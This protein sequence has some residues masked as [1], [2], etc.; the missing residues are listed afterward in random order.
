MFLF[1]LPL[2]LFFVIFLILAIP[3]VFVLLQLGIIS[4]AFEK[5]GV[6]A[7]LAILF[8]AISLLT[9][10]IN[11][12]VYKRE[13]AV[14][15]NTVESI[16]INFLGGIPQ[17][18]KE[19]I[20]AINVGGC[21]V[22]V[23]FSF[24]LLTKAPIISTLFGIAIISIVAYVFSRPVPGV[25]IVMPFWIA[26][27]FS[28]LIAMV[29]APDHRALVAYVSGVLGTLIGADILKIGQFMR[30]NPGILSIGGAGVFDGIFLTGIVAAFLS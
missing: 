20:I 28:A 25:G 9:S 26:P 12:P 1:F 23:L 4:F 29:I 13:L 7:N 21:I 30:K 14:P 2:T 27:I 24:Y 11:I 10:S 8:Y 3:F 18:I 15:I 17:I 22:P 16:F 19:Q 5:I 6:P